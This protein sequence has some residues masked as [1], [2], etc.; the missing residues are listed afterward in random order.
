M[1]PDLPV[2]LG[3]KIRQL[4]Q[5]RGW[6]QIDLA[7]HADLSKT[8]VCAVEGGRRELGVGALIRIASALDLKASELLRLAGD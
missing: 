8:H 2:R 4:R 3:K 6:R 7:V 1:T 5:A